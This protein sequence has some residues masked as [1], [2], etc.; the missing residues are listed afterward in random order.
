VEETWELW[1]Q[2]RARARL[3]REI[4]DRQHL[5]RMGIRRRERYEQL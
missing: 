3:T 5:L 2:S 1:Q 4:T